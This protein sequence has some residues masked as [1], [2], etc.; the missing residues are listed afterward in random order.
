MIF[1]IKEKN[2]IL[3]HTVYCLAIATNIPV[4]LMTDFVVQGHIYQL[5]LGMGRLPD[6]LGASAKKLT[7]RCIG[8]KSGHRI[9]IGICIAMHRF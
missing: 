4:Q 6:L 9:Q 2:I 3:T 1:G 7:M 8:L 5:M